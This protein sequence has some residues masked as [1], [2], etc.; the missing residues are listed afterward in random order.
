[1]KNRVL[2]EIVIYCIFMTF[3]FMVGFFVGSIYTANKADQF[4]RGAYFEQVHNDQDI[5]YK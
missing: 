1:M 4:I 2:V 5:L 3:H